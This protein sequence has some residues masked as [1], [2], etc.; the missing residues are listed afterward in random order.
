MPRIKNLAE[1]YSAL[2]A[3]LPEAM[4]AVAK[5]VESCIQDFIDLFYAEYTPRVYD[6]T[7]Q[8]L[9]SIVTAQV[10]RK[11]GRV[12]TMVFVNARGMHYEDPT[13]EVLERVS[14]G[15]HGEHGPNY[16]TAFWDKGMDR[17]ESQ[18]TIIKEFIKYM[19]GKGY[20]VSL[21]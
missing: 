20:N 4:D 8:F 3:A 6:R 9:N 21:R 18:D 7:Y 5:E 12:E 15:Q 16:G 19:R 1:L 11:G 14:R 10:V 13:D 17:L 2:D